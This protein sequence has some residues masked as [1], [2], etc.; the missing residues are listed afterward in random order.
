MLSRITRMKLHAFVVI[1]VVALSITAMNFVR[2]PQQLGVG[3]YELNVELANAGGLYPQAVVTYRGVEVGKVTDVELGANGS[4]V[5]R[6]QVDNGVKIP[7]ESSVEVRSASVIGEQYVNFVPLP[8]RSSDEA[9]KDGATVPVGRTL[10]PTTTNTLLTSLDDLLTSIPRDD[11]RTTVRELGAATAGVDDEL[12][13]FVEA[14]HT[15]QQAATQN[16]PATLK[17]LDDTGPVLNTQS[18]LDPDIRAFARDLG[19]FTGALKAADAQLRGVLS[20]G[21]P[22]MRQIGAFSEELK[23]VLPGLFADTA[24]LGQV[25]RVYKDNIEHVLILAPAVVPALNAAIPVKSR[26]AR[27]PANLWF[28]LSVDPPTCSVGFPDAKD[29]RNPQDIS[30]TP[31]P[32]MAWCKAAKDDPRTA[33]GARNSPCP[34]GGTG[35]TAALCGLIFD[36]SAVSRNDDADR[37]TVAGA[38][39]DLGDGL[40]GLLLGSS[41]K[42]PDSL[43]ELLTGL[44]T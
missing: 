20:A 16:L 5:A 11:L 9:F 10:V 44:L 40:V 38:T 24:N 15:F 17:L 33:R 1:T 8:G 6:L 41:Q 3:R 34:N 26:G 23:P 7:S 22:F 27:S 35:A 13:R 14:S 19:S 21:A 4:V 37:G 31:A 39:G 2:L 42:N 25:L 30:P 12:A 36:K 43:A 28:K 29:I 18:S 32:K